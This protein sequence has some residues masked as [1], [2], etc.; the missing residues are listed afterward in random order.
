MSLPRLLRTLCNPISK[1][2][3]FGSKRYASI[4]SQNNNVRVSAAVDKMQPQK[5]DHFFVLDFEATCLRDQPLQPQEIIEFPCIKV[6]A[7]DFSAR[8]AETFHRY[9]KPVHHPNLSYFCTE[10]T[11]ITQDMVDDE[12]EFSEVL[13]DFDEWVSNQGPG[14]FTFVICGDWDL[15][16]MLTNQCEVKLPT[17]FIQFNF[18]GEVF[19]HIVIR[20]SNVK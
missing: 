11:G 20:S 8:S 2:N 15:K 1:R 3:Y 12:A 13:K 19:A 6:N 18:L 10:L 16:T 17:T 14:N 7:V 9:V 4:K 5:F